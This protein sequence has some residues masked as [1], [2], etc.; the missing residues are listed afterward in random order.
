MPVPYSFSNN[1]LFLLMDLGSSP[2]SLSLFLSLSVEKWT[3][4]TY[5][6]VGKSD[7]IFFIVPIFKMI[8][9]VV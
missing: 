9:H 4:E 7:F 1:G 8:C 2:I 3:A 5:Q 6:T